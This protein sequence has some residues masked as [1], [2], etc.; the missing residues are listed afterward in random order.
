MS[1]A[2]SSTATVS[3]RAGGVFGK[4][5]R[6]DKH[7]TDGHD[8]LNGGIFQALPGAERRLEFIR[9]D[10]SRSTKA[11]PH[12]SRNEPVTGYVVRSGQ[13]HAPLRHERPQQAIE[14]L[15]DRRLS[16]N[17]ERTVLF[18]FAD[19]VFFDISGHDS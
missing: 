13:L 16:F 18:D 3:R 6:C 7:L 11:M 17:L 10:I 4:R 12:C 14:R 5:K 8:E 1:G 15:N 2:A 9:G 19:G